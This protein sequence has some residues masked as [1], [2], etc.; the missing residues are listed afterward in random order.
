VVVTKGRIEAMLTK[1]FI[2]AGENYLKDVSNRLEILYHNTGLKARTT[3]KRETS[4]IRCVSQN[5]VPD[6]TD[7]L[8][9]LPDFVAKEMIRDIEREERGGVFQPHQFH[10]NIHR[11]E[12]V[13]IEY[14]EYCSQASMDSQDR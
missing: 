14:Y 1:I 5:L 6:G 12:N 8:A 3:N 2:R 7:S 13:S 11:Y 4:P 10:K 9:V